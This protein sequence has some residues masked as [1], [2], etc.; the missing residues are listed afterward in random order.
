MIACDGC[1]KQ[2]LMCWNPCMDC[3]KARYNAVLKRRCCCGKQR[4]ENPKV[5][6]IGSRTW[7]TCDRCLGQTRQLS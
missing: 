2:V 1:G 4:R 6:K 3:V 7:M 5:H